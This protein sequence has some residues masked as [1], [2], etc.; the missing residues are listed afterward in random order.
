MKKVTI[1]L[2][3]LSCPSCMQK[4]EAGVGK[5][6]GVKK[7]KVLFNASKVKAEYDA[8]ITDETRLKSV[9]ENLGFTVESMNVQTV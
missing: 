7:V 2:D 9:I 3:T 5:Q 6:A 8:S 4:I 1:Q